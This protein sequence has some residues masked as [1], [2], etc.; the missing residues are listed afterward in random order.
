VPIKL[1]PII[2][3]T[4][5]NFSTILSS[6]SWHALPGLGRDTN[7]NGAKIYRGHG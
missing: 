4:Y 5:G 3:W 1:S 7:A 6:I 2:Y